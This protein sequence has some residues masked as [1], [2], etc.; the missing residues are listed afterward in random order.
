KAFEYKLAWYLLNK[1][2]EPL[3]HHIKRMEKLGYER[4]PLHVEEAAL[5]YENSAGELPDMGGLSIRREIRLRFKQ[6]F[7]TYKQM[8][9][10]QALGRQ[11]MR[12]QFS[13][14]FW[15]YFHFKETDSG[16]NK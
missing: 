7:S 4:I 13:N 3:V 15:F 12:N 11:Q 16:S 5:A 2:V 1:N 8:Q 14:T 9:Q 10:N 6:Y